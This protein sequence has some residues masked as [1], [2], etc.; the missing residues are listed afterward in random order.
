MPLQNG[1]LFERGIAAERSMMADTLRILL[2]EDEFLVGMMLEE[3]L[4][5]AGHDVI[6]PIGDFARL[7]DAVRSDTFELALLDINLGG[8]MVY[9]AAEELRARGVP[10][11]F[12]SGYGRSTLPPAFKDTTVLSKPC[13]LDTLETE[14]L[15]V[16][17][18]AA[19]AT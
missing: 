13:N 9:P 1:L 5:L 15:R 16:A 6:G 12:L 11:I 19:S 4:R 18:R 17:R 3:S 7:M 8:Q 10:F 2:A 14:V